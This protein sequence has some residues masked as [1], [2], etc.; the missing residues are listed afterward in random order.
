MGLVS[1]D[2]LEDRERRRQLLQDLRTANGTETELHDGRVF[3]VL[4]LP[5]AV[6]V[7]RPAVAKTQIRMPRASRIA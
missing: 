4:H 7:R 5:P 6:P 2:D 3:T 1:Y